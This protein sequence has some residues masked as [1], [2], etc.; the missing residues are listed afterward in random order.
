MMMRRSSAASS[1]ALRRSNH[2]TRF[3]GLR[4]LRV[5]RLWQVVRRGAHN[6]ILGLSGEIAYNAIFS[7][8]PAIFTMLTAIGLFNLPDRQLQDMLIELQRV[9]P[10]E[11]T[12]LVRIVIDEIQGSSNQGLF[13]LSFLLALWISSS[14]MGS[15]MSALD[16]IYQ[17]PRRKKRPFWKAKLVSI[18]LSVGT[19]LLLLGVTVTVFIGELGVQLIAKKS[20]AIADR[21]I[22]T[23][24]TLSLP[25][26][27]AIVMVT[28]AFIYRYGLSG[29]RR[30]SAILPGVLTATGLWAIASGGFRYYVIHFGN[31][32]Q[33]YGAVGA[34]MI[35]LL[36]L[37]VS[38]FAL[39]VGAQVN[40]VL[41]EHRLR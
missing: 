31:Y 37:Y 14:V 38:A 3:Y 21:L 18:G 7:I 33:V 27:L 1:P 5:H 30:G 28:I 10:A 13:S 25:V 26:A 32:N 22:E 2:R 15:I 36:W 39:L 34:V 29:W 16:Q 4:S 23:W 24:Q 8:F 12:A 6:R 19:V 41:D 35:L 17:V 20:G 11:A 9:I 40:R